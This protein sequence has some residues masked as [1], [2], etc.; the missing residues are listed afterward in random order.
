M[1]RTE[2][3]VSEV[4]PDIGHKRGSGAAGGVAVIGGT[5]DIWQVQQVRACSV[6]G[7]EWS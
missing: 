7:S 2:T 4:G 5:A 1:V 6:A 3:P